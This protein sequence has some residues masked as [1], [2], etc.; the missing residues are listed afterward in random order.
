MGATG[1]GTTVTSAVGTTRLVLG[2]NYTDLEALTLSGIGGPELA[3]ETANTYSYAGPIAINS[4]G[5]FVTTLAGSTLQLPGVISG[6]GN[7]F[8][9]GV[10]TLEFQNT[11]NTFVGP[12]ILSD[13]GTLAITA[14]GSL[15]GSGNTLQS[16]SG[17]NV[18]L[19]FDGNTTFTH[20]LFAANPG[21]FTFDIGGGGGR[22]V[23]TTGVISGGAPTLE[24]VGTGGVLTM[25]GAG[26]TYTGNTLI[27]SGTLA[28]DGNTI[29]NNITNNDTLRLEGAAT[30]TVTGII[31][32]TGV[33]N[34]TG[35]GTVT[36]SGANTYSGATNV[37]QGVLIAT[38]DAALGTAAG[39]TNIGSGAT[40]RFDTTAGVLN[41]SEN[42]ATNGGTLDKIG[43]NDLNLSGT[44]ALTGT[45]TI[46]VSAGGKIAL[47]GVASGAGGF[48]KTG[49]G[50]LDLTGA[51]ANTFDGNVDISQ[52]GL[53]AYKDA[54]FG[55][56]VGNLTA[57][58]GSHVGFNNVAYA[59]TESLVLSGGEIRAM[60]ASSFAPC[61]RKAQLPSY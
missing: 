38:S 46:G 35:T 1:S 31:S 12:M 29:R 49:A 7:L 56:A 61:R 33:L 36:L 27:S 58:A 25:A 2:T 40:L 34:K 3:V 37:N 13:S 18:T 23:T 6:T 11:A 26:N 60:G 19:R 57:S 59:T 30:T 55:S 24:V 21:T 10:G 8:K 22:T 51:S 53:W 42:L 15:G 43:A 17:A 47:S 45:S 4:T 5:R 39:G 16:G 20:N 54:A 50:N 9:L 28:G 48:S 52:G 41:V 32:G 44:L 14:D